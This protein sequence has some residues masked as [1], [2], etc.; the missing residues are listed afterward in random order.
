MYKNYMFMMLIGKM[1][2][3]DTAH[4]CSYGMQLK[5]KQKLVNMAPETKD[6]RTFVEKDILMQHG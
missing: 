1:P 2:L 5:R 3:E 4:V 6:A